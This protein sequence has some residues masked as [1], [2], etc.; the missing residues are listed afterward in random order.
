MH[1]PLV[2]LGVA[3]H[4][5]CVDEV[6]CHFIHGEGFSE[7]LGSLFILSNAEDADFLSGFWGET[8]LFS[9]VSVL[10]LFVCAMIAV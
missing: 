1:L 2:L 4:I 6:A 10:L 3:R 7:T 8:A 5:I 9:R